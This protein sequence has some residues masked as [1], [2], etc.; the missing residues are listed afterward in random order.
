MSK[1]VLGFEQLYSPA[2][3]SR[4]LGCSVQHIYE[5]INTGELDGY[6]IGMVKCLRVP[7]GSIRRYLASRRIDPE[8]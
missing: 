3:V 5:L 6:R 8:I 1:N 2:A 4:I 7:E